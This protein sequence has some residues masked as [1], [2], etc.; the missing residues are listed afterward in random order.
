MTDKEIIEIF[1]KTGGLLKGHF[2]LT[3]GRHSDQYM[4]C[5]KVFA[6]PQYSEIL[7]AALA[8]KLSHLEID[9]VAS[10]AIGGIIMGYSIS[11]HLG[12][13]NIFAEREE[14]VMTFRRGFTL[15]EGEK[16]LVV[17]D[18][19]TTGGSVKEVMEL[20][21]N[22]GGEVVAVACIVDRSGGKVD[23]G[24]PFFSLLSMEINFY[25]SQDCPI[26]RE[27]KIP[28]IKPGSRNFVSKAKKD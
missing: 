11:N 26:C 24:K 22:N 27:G 19:V 21:N 15:S 18:V 1:Q 17:E 10:P 13:R 16:C 12:V 28:L 3:S 23:F 14:G 2:L 8:S 20:I 6:S 9:C 5:A 4:Q 7:C 25:P